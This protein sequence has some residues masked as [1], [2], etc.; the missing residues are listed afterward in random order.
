[1]TSHPVSEAELA[2]WLGVESRTVRNQVSSGVI[3]Q[4]PGKPVRYDLRASLQ[5]YCRFLSDRAASRGSLGKDGADL[6]AQRARGAREQA[7]K[8]AMQNAK[9][10]GELVS[11]T[12]CESAWT[13]TV[14]QLR[15]AM[16]AVPARV[17][18]RLPHLTADDVRAL[19]IEVR[20]AMRETAHDNGL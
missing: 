14:V 4:L 2:A 10:R 17:Q 5:R 11:L 8:L 16:L 20:S 3:E 13:G 12:A 18:Q 19:E 15:Q 7:D 9:L 6:T 1:M